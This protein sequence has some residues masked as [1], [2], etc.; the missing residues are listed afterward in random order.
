MPKLMFDTLGC[1]DLD[2]RK[3]TDGVCNMSIK[4]TGDNLLN[5][6]D[7][8]RAI[9]QTPHHIVAYYNDFHGEWA[10][11]W[12]ASDCD[13]VNDT[14]HWTGTKAKAIQLAKFYQESI[15]KERGIS[16]PIYKFSR[17]EVPC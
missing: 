5:L 9:G 6:H 7:Y 8:H 1:D 15:R 16:C 10:M 4:L 11:E 2:C 12:H 14:T 3:S 17:S 13:L